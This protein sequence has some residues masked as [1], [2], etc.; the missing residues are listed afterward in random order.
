[1]K[2]PS[3]YTQGYEKA[4]ALEPDIASNYVAHATIGD[5]VA[6]AA[7]EEL[8]SLDRAEATVFISALM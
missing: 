6:D 7:I 5:P 8:A 3:D 4:R 1:M 2:I